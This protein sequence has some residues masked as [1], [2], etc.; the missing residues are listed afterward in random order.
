VTDLLIL[1]VLAAPFILLGALIMFLIITIG[2]ETGSGG[3]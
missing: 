3:R 2:R 1:L